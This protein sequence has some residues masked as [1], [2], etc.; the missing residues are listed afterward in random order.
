MDILPF[1]EVEESTATMPVT[2]YSEMKD[3]AYVSLNCNQRNLEARRYQNETIRTEDVS[4][5]SR[6][7]Y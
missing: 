4:C 3:N 2:R 5:V 1:G 6:H 7:L